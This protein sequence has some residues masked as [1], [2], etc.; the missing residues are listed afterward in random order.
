MLR[1]RLFE[2]APEIAHIMTQPC[3]T[4]RVTTQIIRQPWRRQITNSLY[5]G[6]GIHMFAHLAK[7]K[8]VRGAQHR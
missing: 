4:R 3:T 1:E 7:L 5:G 8:A 6:T 2:R